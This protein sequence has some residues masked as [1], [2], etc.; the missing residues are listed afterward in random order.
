MLAKIGFQS[1]TLRH[2][3][4]C[5]IPAQQYPTTG[6]SQSNT[7][8]EKNVISI[9]TDR[10]KLRLDLIFVPFSPGFA[11]FRQTPCGGVAERLNALVLKTSMSVRASQVRILSPP[12]TFLS[13]SRGIF[14][15]PLNPGHIT[16]LALPTVPQSL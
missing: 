15:T 10:P 16:G 8:A 9:D 3:N 1:P 13:L 11:R 5:T 2:W 6:R 14:L 4:R 7:G 12:P